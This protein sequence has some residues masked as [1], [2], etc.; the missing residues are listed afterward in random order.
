MEDISN[1]WADLKREKHKKQKYQENSVLEKMQAKKSIMKTI[2][3][4][5][6]RSDWVNKF[7]KQIFEG[8]FFICTVCHRC[9][10]FQLV[11]KFIEA[12]YEWHKNKNYAQPSFDGN[13]YACRTCHNKLRKKIYLSSSL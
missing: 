11:Q 12:K 7:R 13:F 1:I 8:P 10:Y 3:A 4:G 9:L 2:Y 5:N 6:S